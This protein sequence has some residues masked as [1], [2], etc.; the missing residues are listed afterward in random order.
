[1]ESNTS[2]SQGIHLLAQDLIT[3]S[4]PS[5]APDGLL[6][7]VLQKVDSE[8]ARVRTNIDGEITAINPAFSAL[9]GYSFSEIRG[10]KPGSFLQGPG[11]DATE[12]DAVREAVKAA[13]PVQVELTNYHKDGSAYRVHISISPQY[14]SQGELLGFEAEERE[15]A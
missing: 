15:I 8:P 2:P 13:R 14:N 10:Q 1:M 7:R 3:S 11:T 9:C 5:E 6:D 12:V 4:G